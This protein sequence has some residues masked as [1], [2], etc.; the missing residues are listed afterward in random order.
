MNQEW[1]R[2]V[3]THFLLTPIVPNCSPR[4]APLAQILAENVCLIRTQ[5]SGEEELAFLL[6]G[7]QR[8]MSLQWPC[9]R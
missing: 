7:K 2:P 8:P 5:T 9:L 3:R 4:S 1:E 6:P